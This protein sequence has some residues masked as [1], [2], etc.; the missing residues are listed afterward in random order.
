MSNF[1]RVLVGALFLVLFSSAVHAQVAP[2]P[3]QGQ[4][5]GGF[6]GLPVDLLPPGARSLGLAG[7]FTAVADDATAAVANPAGLANLSTTEVSVHLRNFDSDVEFFDPDAYDTG[8]SHLVGDINKTYSDSGSEVSFA[9]I[10]KPFDS[11]VLSAYYLNQLNFQSDQLES[12]I[13]VDEIFLDTY[14]NIHS[15]DA[16]IEGYGASVA[17]RIS[18]TFSIGVTVQNTKLDLASSDVWILD[19][20]NGW[21]FL[22][23]NPEEALTQLVDKW[24]I[25]TEVGHGKGSDS[26]DKDTT[27]NVGLLW[28]V[29][30]KFSVG[31]VYREGAEFDLQSNRFGSYKLGCIDG[32]SLPEADCSEL[33]D[34][35][36]VIG[37]SDNV[38][39]PVSVKIP[40]TLSLGFAWRPANTLLVS[41]DINNIGYSDTAQI[42]TLTQGFTFQINE[43]PPHPSFPYSTFNDPAITDRTKPWTEKIKDE[44]TFHLG[45][46]KV[47]L[48]PGEF[49][50]SVTLRGG[51]FTVEDH[52]GAVDIDSSDTVLTAGLG[53]VMGGDNRGHK[54]FQL[55]LGASFGD[56]TT[57]II[58]SGIY[59][60]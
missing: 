23:P 20:F 28:N 39:S 6:S 4:A 58:L 14:T 31:L 59:R 30:Q 40:D 55:D 19:H 32:S 13:D 52:D 37:Y 38:Q 56:N 18:S 8:W 25:G 50:S 26:S 3:E 54:Q 47:F 51:A 48:R 57:N 24:T 41:L 44:T 35:N 46:E 15:I 29:S 49:L 16:A 43:D 27:F 21:E 22:Y 34:V 42:R 12:G 5:G 36:D 33:A 17:Y 7:A 53:V 1:S 60:F 45:V 2:A 11:W 10:V 9:S